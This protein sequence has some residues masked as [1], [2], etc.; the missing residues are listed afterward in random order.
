MLTFSRSRLEVFCKKDDLKNF[1]NLSWKHLCRLRPATLLK[2]RVRHGR[3]PV[4]FVEIL[5]NSFSPRT[6]SVAASDARES[7]QSSL[8]QQ[9][10]RADKKTLET[11]I[12]S[13]TIWIFQLM[14]TESMFRKKLNTKPRSSHPE[15]F[16][17][18]GALRNF[19][20]FREKHPCQNLFFNKL[21]LN[22]DSD[23]LL[24]ILWNF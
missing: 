14:L 21:Y 8:K 16:C 20:K 9:T 7:N 24:W 10:R 18:K 12:I 19:A 1:A 5:K 6:P 15:V 2:N 22:R 4:K 23:V 3:F 11:F 17:K 13:W